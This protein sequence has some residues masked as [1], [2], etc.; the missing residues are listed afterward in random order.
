MEVCERL[1]AVLAADRMRI[2]AKLVQIGTVSWGRLVDFN[3]REN[4]LMRD[5][6]GLDLG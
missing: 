5:P 4:E 1:R 2:C 6:Y 3:A